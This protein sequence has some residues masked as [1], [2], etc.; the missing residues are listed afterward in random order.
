MEVTRKAAVMGRVTM[1]AAVILQLLLKAGAGTLT[2]WLSLIN[3]CQLITRKE[4]Q[5]V[6]TLKFYS[7]VV[8]FPLSVRG[9]IAGLAKYTS[10]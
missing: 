10:L 8:V 1:D 9:T 3:R 4:A 5:D 7:C 6:Q 2:L